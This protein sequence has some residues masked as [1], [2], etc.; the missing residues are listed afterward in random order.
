[1]YVFSK[2]L[3]LLL[4]TTLERRQPQKQAISNTERE[5][6]IEGSL[7]L[8]GIVCLVQATSKGDAAAAAPH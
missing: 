4:L 7:S 2:S 1:M 5:R 3:L 8:Q 6:E